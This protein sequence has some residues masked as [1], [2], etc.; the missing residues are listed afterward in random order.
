VRALLTACVLL[1]PATAAAAAEQACWVDN[2][3][4]VVTAEVA[5]YVG[6]Y[7]LDTGQAATQLAETQALGMGYAAPAVAG[8]VRLAGV[9]A[10]LP[11]IPIAD[12]DVRTGLLPTPIAG[13]IGADALK[14]F[15][16]DLDLAPCRLRLSRPGEAPPAPRGMRLPLT[17]LDGRPTVAAAVSDGPRAFRGPFAISTGLDAPVRLPDAWT[18]PLPAEAYP[19]GVLRPSLRALSFGG[20]LAENVPAGLATDAAGAIG[21]PVLARWRLRFDYPRGELRLALHPGR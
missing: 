14:G 19:Y 16:L 3:V 5:G 2:G 13:V 7:I 8:E 9:R 18:R 17:W 1:A 6:D 4:V 10:S 15:V 11:A 21:A 20:E 12:L